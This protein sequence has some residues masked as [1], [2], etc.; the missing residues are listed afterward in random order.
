MGDEGVKIFSPKRDFLNYFL[1][2]SINKMEY[3]DDKINTILI[4]IKWLDL[5]L[6]CLASLV[7]QLIATFANPNS[8]NFRDKHKLSKSYEKSF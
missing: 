4:A 8:Y 6:N 3:T 2:L 5:I 1:L 7:G